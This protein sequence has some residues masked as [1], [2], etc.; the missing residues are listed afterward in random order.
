[1]DRRNYLKNILFMG[2][3]TV[4]FPNLLPN[5][6]NQKYDKT[7]LLCT[8]I[9][10]AN[11]GDGSHVTGILTLLNTYLPEAK[12]ILW[13]TIN[14]DQFDDM[15]RRYWPDV[16]IVHSKFENG[17]PESNII[18]EIV[19]N[20]DFIIGGH[21]QSYKVE[22]VAEKYN[23]PYGVIGV[24]VGS[25]P[26]GNTKKFID[27]AEFYFTRET[28]S[29]HNL[30]TA[31]V[32]CPLIGFAPDASF[33]S[34]VLEL[35][36]A[37]SFMNRHQ[38][39]YKKFLCVVP[40][41]RVTP[42]YRI[43]PTLKHQQAPWTQDRIREVDELNNKH[44]E[45]DHAKARSAIIAYVQRTGNLVLLCPEMIHNLDLFD[46][47]LYDPLPADVKKYVIKRK[48]FWTTDEATT[49]YKQAQAVISLECHS[50]I[51]ALIQ[52]TPSFYL[53]QPEDTIKGQMYYDIGLSDWVFEIEKTSHQDIIDELMKVVNEYESARIKVEN[54]MDYVR[55][56]QR[57]CMLDIRKVVG[58]PNTGYE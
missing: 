25:P 18:D 7:I 1:M 6:L 46:E 15:I 45:T 35:D 8:G 48:H 32:S 33:G 20:V 47:L 43:A 14:V 58:L 49:I 56:L 51:I 44:K 29:Y 3:S 9:Q 41:L 34:N 30:K 12:I 54:S 57:K 36:R 24:T 17:E 21:S 5:I 50:P 31:N 13:P 16:R 52:G 38:L 2:G 55:H 37:V 10:F 19:Q 23:K 27:K 39:Q 4:L 22:W 53:R 42:Y 28:A 40:R 26:S 11:I